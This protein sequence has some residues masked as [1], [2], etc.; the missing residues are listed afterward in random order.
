MAK[1]NKSQ[2]ARKRAML[3]A[4][5]RIGLVTRAALAAK[6]ERTTHYKWLRED[7]Q[8]AAEFAEANEEFIE[9]LEEEADRRAV[10]GTIRPVF[11]QGSQ[12]GEVREHSDTLL[13]FRLKAL[14]PEVYRERQEH[15]HTGRIEQAIRV[16]QDDDWY[17]NSHRLAAIA[18]EQSAGGAASSSAVQA[19]RVR[20]AVG[21]NGN[22]SASGTK[23]PRGETNGHAGG[24]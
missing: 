6:I 16:V 15:Q 17:G 19:G 2:H 7:P 3:K 1:T 11:Y 12:C 18:P 8:Y 13:I 5:A 21:K 22:G 9:K 20:P 23:R 4:F 10:D 24:D 14:R